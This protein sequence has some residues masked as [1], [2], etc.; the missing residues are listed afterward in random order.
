MLPFDGVPTSLDLREPSNENY[1]FAKIFGAFCLWP[2]LS[3]TRGDQSL[4]QTLP[5]GLPQV[6]STA[7]QSAD[8]HTGG[9]ILRVTTREVLVDVVALDQHPVNGPNESDFSIYE[10]AKESKK[11]SRKI[12]SFR[13]VDPALEDAQTAP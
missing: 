2:I 9:F 12:S 5:T 7:E 11:I 4:C 10:V 3:M 13:V 6:S 1:L 8:S